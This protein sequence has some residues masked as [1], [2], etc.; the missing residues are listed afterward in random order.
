[1]SRRSGCTCA[2]SARAAATLALLGLLL[3]QTP[4][5]PVAAAP[6]LPA[7]PASPASPLSLGFGPSSLFPA[8]GGAPVYTVGETIWVES[9]YNHSVSLSLSSPGVDGKVV[10]E[11]T[12]DPLVVAPLYTFTSTDSEGLWNVTLEAPQGPVVV[13]VRFVNPAQHRPSLLSPFQYSLDGGNISISASANLGGGYDQEV[14]AAGSASEN[15]VTLTLPRAMGDLGSLSLIPG[16]PSFG[17]STLGVLNGSVSFWFELYQQYS[18]DPGGSNNLVAENVMVAASRP[19]DIVANGPTATTLSL[20]AP[21]RAGRYEMRAFFQNSTSLS[22]LESRVLVLNSS[23]WVSLAACPAQQVRSSGISY[24]APLTD[25]Q[26]SWPRTLYYMYRES[27]VEAVDSFPLKANVSSVTFEAS[28]WGE[29]V[30]DAQV[31][32]ASSSGVLQSTTADG[33]LFILASSY[34]ADVNYSLS[35]G[36]AVALSPRV[37][38]IRDAYSTQTVEVDL[39]QLTVHLV[40]DQASPITLDVSGPGG[41]DISTTPAG[42]NRTVSL[43]LP[44]GPYALTASQGGHSAT[45][46]LQL[47]VGA[48]ETST[49]NLN[50]L[51]GL[52]TFLV[53]TAAIAAVAN[54][55]VWALRA[56]DSR[57]RVPTAPKS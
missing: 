33:S 28:P 23:S 47:S 53:V 18:L 56:K 38:T 31:S 44:A 50:G 32:V 9:G 6:A 46:Q 25:G 40:G 45:A 52:E 29:P 30:Q 10:V 51:T 7:A 24:S 13:P 1:M 49:L 34:P 43:F 39:A 37:L 11:L 16:A 41:L 36:G 48:A 17:L 22:V 27:G 42:G 57:Q 2:G 55:L 3:F 15:P 35:I 21:L 14:C 4:T 26:A 12:L 5:Q 8:S 54:I 19:V 20:D